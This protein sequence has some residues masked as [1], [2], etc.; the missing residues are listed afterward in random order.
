[1][2]I[3]FQQTA[4]DGKENTLSNMRIKSS[5]SSSNDYTK[6]DGP[7]TSAGLFGKSSNTKEKHPAISIIVN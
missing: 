1:M 6:C 5:N 2:N 3:C 4:Q 7:S